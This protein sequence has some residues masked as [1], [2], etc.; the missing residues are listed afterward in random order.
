MSGQFLIRRRQLLKASALGAGY[1]AIG[2]G[3]LATAAPAAQSLLR[4]ASVGASADSLYIEAWPTSPLIKTPFSDPLPIP[5]ALAPISSDVYNTWASVP[6][7]G[8]Q[9]HT[10]RSHSVMPSDL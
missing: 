9:D 5:Q 6:Y 7:K 4:A 10:G 2:G 1:L 8:P 3:A